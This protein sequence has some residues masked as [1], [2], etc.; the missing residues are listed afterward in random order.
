M[1]GCESQI[2]SKQLRKSCEASQ[3]WFYRTILK[4]PWTANMINQN[5]LKMTLSKVK[6]IV[7]GFRIVILQNNV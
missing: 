7:W 6:K 3:M 1:D 4:I 5:I 2:I